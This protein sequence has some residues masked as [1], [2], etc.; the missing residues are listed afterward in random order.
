M[1]EA[2]QVRILV[3][4]NPV[5]GPSSS[6]SS[7]EHTPKSQESLSAQELAISFAVGF[8]HLL[9]IS[10]SQKTTQWGSFQVYQRASDRSILLGC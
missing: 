8:L 4:R 3:L 6:F 7:A 1:G 2:N 9:P 5:P 10:F